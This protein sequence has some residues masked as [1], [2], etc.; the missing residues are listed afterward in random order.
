VANSA[1]KSHKS[2]RHSTRT[3]RSMASSSRRSLLGGVQVHLVADDLTRRQRLGEAG[4]LARAAQH[5]GGGS[6][7][8]AAGGSELV[9]GSGMP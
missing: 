5:D 1:G 8:A 7:D 6:A 9:G 3:G 2:G 4:R